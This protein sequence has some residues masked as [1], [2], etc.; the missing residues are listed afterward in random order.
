M[1]NN[2]QIGKLNPFSVNIN[3][4]NVTKN[5][6]VRHSAPHIHDM[7]EIYVNLEGNVSFI[8]EKNIYAIKPGDIIIVKPYEYH[9]C[10]YHDDS[11]HL[12]YWIMFSADENPELFDFF[13][14]KSRGTDNLIR[15]PADI[16]ERFL[17]LCEKMTMINPSYEISVL[18]VFFEIISHIAKGLDRYNVREANEN[19]PQS[20]KDILSYI[21]KNYDSIKNINELVSKLDISITTLERYF[22]KYLSMTPKRY[23]EDRKLSQACMLLRQNYSVTDACFESGFDDYSHFIAIFKKNFGITPLKYKKNILNS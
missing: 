13:I 11:D 18:A 14:N 22:K 5:S 10:I 8:V 16:L 6:P 7:C 2:V 4:L 21:N 9:H 1:T 15:L 19:L 20:V 17:A 3:K 12:H 23:L